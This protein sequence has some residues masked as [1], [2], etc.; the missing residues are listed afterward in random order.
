MRRRK[1][2][3]QEKRESSRPISKKLRAA[4]LGS[5]RGQHGKKMAC[6]R[7]VPRVTG[8]SGRPT[9]ILSQPKWGRIGTSTLRRL[10]IGAA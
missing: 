3:S 8:L 10:L 9:A 6:V 4:L 7:R 2:E 1:K 5:F